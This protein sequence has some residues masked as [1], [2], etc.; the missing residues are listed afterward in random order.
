MNT[1]KYDTQTRKT[2][3]LD[4]RSPAYRELQ[5]RSA[6]ERVQLERVLRARNEAITRLTKKLLAA[7]FNADEVARLAA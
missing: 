2:M 3:K 1:S 5:Q 7:G 4:Q 6:A